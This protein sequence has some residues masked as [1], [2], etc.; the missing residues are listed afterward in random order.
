MKVE[1]NRGLPGLFEILLHPPA[2]AFRSGGEGFCIRV[3]LHTPAEALRFV[4]DRIA[5]GEGFALA[6]LNLDH[7]VKLATS[8]EFLDAYLRHDAVTADGFPIVWAGRIQGVSLV[9]TTGSDLFLPM[10]NLAAEAGAKIALVGTTGPALEAASKNIAARFPKIRIA[11]TEAPP[12]GFDPASAE[13]AAVLERVRDSGAALCFLALGAPKQE[14]LAARGRAIAPNV[15][16]LSVGASVD[17][18]AGTQRRAPRWVQRCNVEWLWR[19]GTNPRR[20]M[21]RYAF[22][23]AILPGLL[24]RAFLSR[25]GRS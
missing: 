2:I 18:I 11:L 13:A 3:N 5:K 6:T 24:V 1:Q 14:E 21:I 12:F 8:P 9:R 15:G 22:C 17:F 25:K 7:V 16:F 23:A 19:L 10:L 4:G 20:L